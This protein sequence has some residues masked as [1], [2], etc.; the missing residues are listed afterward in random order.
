MKAELDTNVADESMSYDMYSRE[1]D[2]YVDIVPH[3]NTV[4][5]RL[6]D[7]Q[8]LVPKMIGACRINK[9]LVL[10]DL[11]DTMYQCFPLD[12]CFDLVVAKVA[13][14]KIATFHAICAHLNEQHPRLFDDFQHGKLTL[15]FKIISLI[16]VSLFLD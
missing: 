14:R 1:I 10:E 4:L 11:K 16:I 5:R 9:V 8:Q 12:R 6:G 15:W 7:V 3:V 2:F 13:V